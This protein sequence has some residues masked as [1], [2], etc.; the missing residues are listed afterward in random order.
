MQFVSEP[1]EQRKQHFGRVADM[2]MELHDFLTAV[3][4]EIVETAQNFCKKHKINSIILDQDDGIGFITCIFDLSNMQV[5][6]CIA[7]VNNIKYIYVPANR[8][9]KFKQLYGTAE[10]AIYFQEKDQMLLV[11]YQ[12]I[13]DNKQMLLF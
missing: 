2:V 5:Q 9:E 1:Q 10:P 11:I 7:S 13:K 12:M 4:V 6:E 8:I 3:D